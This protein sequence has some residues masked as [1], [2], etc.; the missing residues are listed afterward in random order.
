MFSTIGNDADSRKLQDDIE[1][2][3]AWSEKW[4][5]RFNAKKCKVMHLGRQNINVK[6]NMADVQ[7]KEI[8]EEKDLGVMIDNELKFD[9]H[10]AKQVNKSN[11]QLGLIRRSFDIMDKDTFLLLYKSLVRTHLSL[12]HI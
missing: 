6:Y 12:I 2:L 9:I 3:Q 1:N 5:L 7:L 8:T 11:A 10:V 4:Q